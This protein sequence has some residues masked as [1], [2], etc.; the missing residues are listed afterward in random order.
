MDTQK[1]NYQAPA[2]E[3]GLDILEFLASESISQSQ[4]DIADALGRNQSEIYRMLACLERRG[5]IQRDGSHYGLTLRLYQVG[6]SHHLMTEFRRAA[7]VPMERLAQVTGHS[8]HL[9]MQYAGELMITLERMPA[10][11]LCLS[12]GEGATFPLWRTAS[13]K[14]WLGMVSSSEREALLEVDKAFTELP[15]SFQERVYQVAEVARLDGF[16]AQRSDITDGVFDVA[17]PVGIYGG[18]S[19][20]LALSCLE[21][22]GIDGG[23]ESEML[24]AVKECAKQI[25]RNLG[26]SVAS[27]D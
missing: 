21:S 9:S 1:K 13:G 8:C 18:E 23:S 2:L 5:Y 25:N 16:L 4:S 26:L 6:R 10:K 24:L 7:R 27:N 22:A 12:V 20:V 19:A 11:Q 15:P 14:V 3:K 17:M